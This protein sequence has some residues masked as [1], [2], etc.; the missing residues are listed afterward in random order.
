MFLQLHAQET[1][2]ERATRAIEIQGAPPWSNTPVKTGQK[3][4][5]ACAGPSM[6]YRER[7]H[8]PAHAP[9]PPLPLSFITAACAS[10]S[11]HAGWGLAQLRCP[12]DEPAP[13][14]RESTAAVP[15][16]RLP[17]T[18]PTVIRP[19]P[20]LRGAATPLGRATQGPGDPRRLCTPTADAARRRAWCL[21]S[22]FGLNWD[23]V[24]SR[25]LH[26]AFS[27]EDRG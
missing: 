17:A 7:A 15:A 11:S 4:N 24:F 1:A 5:P 25:E 8:P 22:F 2:S 6:L 3:Q 12:R 26:C 23:A 18:R 10:V 13:P 9:G 21:H 14:L 16:S 20:P 27:L 19:L